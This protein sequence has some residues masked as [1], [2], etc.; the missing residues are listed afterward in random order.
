M[1]ERYTVEQVYNKYLSDHPVY[2]SV[3]F[4]SDDSLQKNRLPPMLV[5]SQCVA[6]SVFAAGRTR[7]AIV[8]PDGLCDICSILSLTFPH[9]SAEELNNS[10]REQNNISVLPDECILKSLSRLLCAL[11]YQYKQTHDTSS[12]KYSDDEPDLESEL[13]ASLLS[14][15]S[16]D[17]SDN[18][19]TCTPIEKLELSVR[20]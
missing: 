12:S 10:V 20:S 7:V 6:D 18:P 13:D 11:I 8:V 4:H 2:E 5:M 17:E 16:D 14:D 15:D 9:T 1:S 19:S 3:E